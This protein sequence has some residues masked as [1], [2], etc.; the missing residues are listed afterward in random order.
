MSES[1][2]SRVER[3]EFLKTAAAATAGLTILPS[4]AAR[5]TQANSKVELG[6]I[7]CGQRGG[8]LAGLVEEQA[9]AKVVAVHDYFRSQTERVGQQLGVG[10]DRQYVGLEGFRE[11]IARPSSS[12]T[13]GSTAIRTG[14]SRS[15]AIFRTTTLCW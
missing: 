8:W 11:L 10:P 5:G 3:R 2:R 15:A 13:V 4:G 14:T 6:L 12:R 1:P 7:G 9:P